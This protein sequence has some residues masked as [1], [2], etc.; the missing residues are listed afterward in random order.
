MPF[1]RIKNTFFN[2]AFTVLSIRKYLPYVLLLNGLIANAQTIQTSM[3][4]NSTRLLPLSNSVEFGTYYANLNEGQKDWTGVRASFIKSFNKDNVGQ[5]QIE[6]ANRFG[7]NGNLAGAS[8]TH[9]FNEDWY[10]GIGG[11]ITSA[12]VFWPRAHY[13]LTISKKWLSSKKLISTLGLQYNNARLGYSDRGALLGLSYYFDMPFVLEIGARSNHSN[14][15]SVKTY[16]GYIAGTYGKEHER[17]V[18]FRFDSGREGYQLFGN[19][20]AT[21][22]NSREINLRWKE[23]VGKEWGTVV[24][25]DDYDNPSYR[26]RG[27]SVSIFKD[28]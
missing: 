19:T 11:Y 10:G 17:Y 8:W 2:S 13:D 20:Q 28:F 7:E 22:F 25:Y 24:S 16:R 3:D 23:W 26:R 9:T 12:G 5:F 18:S 4:D 1:N 6:H 21:D 15:G 27:G 14:P